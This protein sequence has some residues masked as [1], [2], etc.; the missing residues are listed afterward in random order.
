MGTRTSPVWP[1]DVVVVD[2]RPDSLVSDDLHC[3][4]PRLVTANPDPHLLPGPQDSGAIRISH[5]W[6]LAVDSLPAYPALAQSVPA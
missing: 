2:R 3:Q 5:E 4:A 6:S 1:C